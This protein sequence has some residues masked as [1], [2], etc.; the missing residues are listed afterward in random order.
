MV[1]SRRCLWFG[2]LLAAVL[3]AAA[4]GGSSDTTTSG[5]APGTS[6]TLATDAG[7]TSEA[8]PAAKCP[9][10]GDD[11]TLNL[12]LIPSP[13]ADSIQKFIPDFEAA[14]PGVKVHVDTIDYGTA[15]QKELLSIRQ[16]AGAWDVAQ[17]DNT[18]LTPFG[19]GKLMMPLDDCLA[20]SSEYDI[21]DFSKAQQDYG[22]FDGVS[23]GLVLSTEPFIQWYRTDLYDQ[24]GLKPATTW[25]EFV[26]NAK[27]VKDSGKADGM[28]FGWGPS[29]DWWWWWR[30]WSNGGHL[31]DD[32]F[33]PSVNSPEC[34][35]GAQELKDSLQYGPKGGISASGDDATAKFLSGEVGSMVNYSGYWGW[36]TDATKNKISGKIGT[37][38]APKGPTDVTHLAG[39]NIG[40]PADAKNPGLAWKF[41]EFVLGKTNAAKY[42]DSG[43]AAIGR[44]SIIRDPAELAKYPY[45][46]SLDIPDTTNV[47]R[48]PQ[49]VTFPEADTA[50]VQALGDIMTGK[51]EPQAGLDALQAKLEPI[52]AEETKARGQ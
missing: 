24:L 16:K 14:N 6:A 5:A 17:F 11:K 33:K 9:Q 27:A 29:V 13:S 8:P 15:H 34:V 31:Y 50:M 39:W 12:I 37:A 36:T 52:L 46:A 1:R 4:C 10:P 21:A 26:A 18:F 38:P 42:L 45:L 48:Y 7:A 32:S 23:Y 30:C 22:K 19:A 25:D 47:E 2:A 3:V 44:N 20:E 28:I 43:A 51:T 49:L 35:K 40:I 41:L